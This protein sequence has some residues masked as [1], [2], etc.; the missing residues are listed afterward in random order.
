M[1]AIVNEDF[2]DVPPIID[3]LTP[4]AMCRLVSVLTWL[5]LLLFGAG[6]V[7]CGTSG[8]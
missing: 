2:G 8:G 1:T 5:L 6:Y 4:Q 3:H 7:I